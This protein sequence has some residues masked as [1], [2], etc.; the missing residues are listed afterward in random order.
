VDEQNRQYTIF[1][2]LSTKMQLYTF[3]LYLETALHVSGGT[4]THHQERIQLYL[5][6]LLLVTPLLLP[7][8]TVEGLELVWVYCGWRTPKKD[9]R[10]TKIREYRTLTLSNLHLFEQNGPSFNWRM[11]HWTSLCLPAWA[12]Y[13]GRLT[14]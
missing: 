3:Y 12:R 1:Q 10:K 9:Y 4:F 5:Q 11:D 2:Y 6:N 14:L 7:A 8:A 13:R